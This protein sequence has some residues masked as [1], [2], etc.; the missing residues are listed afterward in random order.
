MPFILRPTAI[1][2]RFI[3]L[4]VTIAVTTLTAA[5]AASVRSSIAWQPCPAGSVAA[6]AGGFTC[7]TVNVPLDYAKPHGAMIQLALVKHAATDPKHRIGTLF[8]N[9]GGP[10]GQGLTQIP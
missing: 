1:V 2:A 8:T 9:P 5:H 10:G 3:A 4:C 7:A 6:A